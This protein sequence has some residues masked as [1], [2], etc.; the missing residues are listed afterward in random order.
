MTAAGNQPKPT[1]HHR[2][3]RLSHALYGLI[4]ITATLVAEEE[5]VN[6]AS[7]ALGLVLGTALVLLLAHTYSAMMAERIVKA[8]QLGVI[9]RR[10]V[11]R[12]NVP[13]L[14]AIVVPAALFILSWLG[15]MSLQTADTTSIVFSLVALFGLGIYEGRIASMNWGRSTFSGVAAAGIGVIVV[16]VE[17]FLG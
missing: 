13:V 4:I 9:G 14:F 2:G 7:H 1:T 17:A 16:M 5:H 12:D 3:E 11:I 10:M 15:V 8:D 6:E